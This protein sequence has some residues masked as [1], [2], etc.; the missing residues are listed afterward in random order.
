MDRR[1]LLATELAE[2]QARFEA[3]RTEAGEVPTVQ[4]AP[5]DL[6]AGGSTSF[7]G[8]DPS[9]WAHQGKSRFHGFRSGGG[10][11]VDTHGSV[12]R[13]SRNQT[14]TYGGW[15]EKV[16]R[17]IRSERCSGL[18]HPVAPRHQYGERCVHPGRF[19]VWMRGRVGVRSSCGPDDTW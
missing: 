17:Q 13:R 8:N 19:R 12:D 7:C 6:Y 1:A 5:K 18:V 11:T 15:V 16:F 10:F 2:G 14:T 3:L 4:S 9:G